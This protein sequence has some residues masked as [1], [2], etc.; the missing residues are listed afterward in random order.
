MKKNNDYTATQIEDFA[1]ETDFSITEYF[2]EK[3]VG[4][5][6]ILISHPDKDIC[7][8]FV[9]TGSTGSNYIY[10]CIYSDL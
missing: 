2:T 10:T 9:L 7:A 4:R 5:A 3:T 8:S 6:F 1:N